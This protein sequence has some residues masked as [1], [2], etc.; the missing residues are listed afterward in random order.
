MQ[1]TKAEPSFEN[2]ASF[3]ETKKF[4]TEDGR[5]IETQDKDVVLEHPNSV[6]VYNQWTALRTSGQ[7]PKAR[8]EVIFNSLVKH[9]SKRSLCVS[10]LFSNL[11]YY[12]RFSME[13]SLFKIK[14]MCMVETTTDVI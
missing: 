6:Y 5:L 1:S 13:Q 8:Y 7:P 3:G 10:S 12:I 14:C 2:G 4:S 9:E 11:V